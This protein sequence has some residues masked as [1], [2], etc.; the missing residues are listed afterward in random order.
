M[1]K[2]SKKTKNS[3]IIISGILLLGVVAFL[4]S[5]LSQSVVIVHNAKTIPEKVGTFN[6]NGYIG[7]YK[8]PY[9][10]C[11]TTQ[12]GEDSWSINN[13]NDGD[14]TICNSIT[15]G[16]TLK[17]SSSVSSYNRKLENYFL[18]NIILPEGKLYVSYTYSQSI[19]CTASVESS[20]FLIKVGDKKIR[21]NIPDKTSP[22]CSGTK[23]SGSFTIEIEDETNI[24]IELSTKTTG[25]HSS[26]SSVGLTLNFIPTIVE[27]PEVIVDEEPVSEEPED[28]VSEEVIEKARNWFNKNLPVIIIISLTLFA[29]LLVVIKKALKKKR[30]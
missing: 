4:I 16:E 22:L 7:N 1:K 29:G 26:G 24:P 12:G 19:E 28:P 25:Y 6:L 30:K 21:Q 17:I 15:D 3:L 9:L 27:E 14:Q 10:G 5:G 11:L 8:T 20:L 13:E 2:L 18:G 23:G